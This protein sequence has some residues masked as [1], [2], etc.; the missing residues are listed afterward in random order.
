M[1]LLATTRSPRPVLAPLLALAL[2]FLTLGQTIAARADDAGGARTTRDAS[3]RAAAGYALPTTIDANW[4]DSARVLRDGRAQVTGS[5]G[6]P[7]LSAGRRVDLQHLTNEGWQPLATTVS[8][9][10]GSFSLTIPT[11]WYTQHSLRVIAP[12]T[13]TS[14]SAATQRT[15]LGVVPA[16]APRGRRA[17]HGLTQWRFDP[18]QT[19]RYRIN[20]GQMPRGAAADVHRAFRMVTRATGLT[21][22]HAGT[23]KVVPLQH[24]GGARFTEAPHL[25]NAEF[26]VGWATPAQVPGLRGDVIGL[27]GAQSGN[28]RDAR[29][30][31][32]S[33]S[34]QV[35]IDATQRLR[36]GFGKGY[37]RGEL[38]MHEIGHAL[39]LEHSS[40]RHQVMA[41]SP[42]AVDR[43]GAGDLEGLRQVGRSAG[44]FVSTPVL[45][46]VHIADPDPHP[47]RSPTPLV[48]RT[49][50]AEPV[51]T[52]RAK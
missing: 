5:V 23:S 28:G 15:A 40:N 2:T 14:D 34:G 33:G 12:A 1:T 13:R 4:P 16:D 38:L 17:Q 20:V 30:F 26:L 18:C 27:G 35:V 21:F 42:L 45:G 47:T 41:S 43:F 3:P 52:T 6:L 11:S 24:W 51:W 31:S 46:R 9:L 48:S 7:V 8:T 39:G 50:A 10:T 49:P 19:I 44:C 22:V 37:T 25:P 29:G 36:G 32:L